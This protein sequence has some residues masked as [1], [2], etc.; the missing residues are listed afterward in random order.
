MAERAD[1]IG[2]AARTVP[3]RKPEPRAEA[4]GVCGSVVN[5]VCILLRSE[6]SI[7]LEDRL[8]LSLGSSSL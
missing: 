8:L 5:V 3:R 2:P 6:R 7:C 1:G 4:G